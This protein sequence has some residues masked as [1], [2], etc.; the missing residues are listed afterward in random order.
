MFARKLIR[1]FSTIIIEDIE[2]EIRAVTKLCAKGHRNI[3]QVRGHDWLSGSPYYAIDMEYC[4]LTLGEYIR[5]KRNLGAP[6]H[7]R[8][9][10]ANG[11]SRASKW[12]EFCKIM[13]DIIN[14]VAFIHSCKEVHRDLKP[15]NGFSHLVW[16]NF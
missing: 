5:E 10:N 6:Y 1:P 7:G 3:I 16:T 4:E 9:V 14:G 11:D 12:R 8:G 15:S 13:L 2:N